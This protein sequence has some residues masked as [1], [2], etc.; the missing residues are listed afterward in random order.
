VRIEQISIGALVDP[1]GRILLTRRPNNK[2][3]A[4]LWEFPGGKIENN[5]LP[6]EALIRELKEELS[7]ETRKSCLAPVTFVLH[8]YK[9]FHAILFLFICRRWNGIPNPLEGQEMTWV[10]RTELKQYQMPEANSFLVAILRDW[11]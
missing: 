3:M 1:E 8:K 2:K 4:K 7:I 6:D 11:I 10:R 9:D 5:E